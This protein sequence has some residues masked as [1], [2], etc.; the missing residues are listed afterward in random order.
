MLRQTE[1]RSKANSLSL[2]VTNAFEK[3]GDDKKFLVALTTK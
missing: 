1:K 2:T 3:F